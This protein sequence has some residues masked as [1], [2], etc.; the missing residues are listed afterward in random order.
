MRS[1]SLLA[2][3]VIALATAATPGTGV[4]GQIDAAGDANGNPSVEKGGTLFVRGRAANAATGTAV[5]SVRILDG[6]TILGNATLAESGW[7]FQI[8][9]AALTL[10]THTI[11]AV[12]PG[13]QDTVLSTTNV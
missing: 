11:K 9:T 10:G 1:S 12:V 2:P 8:S 3:L 7:K 13:V 6:N 4:T 5:A